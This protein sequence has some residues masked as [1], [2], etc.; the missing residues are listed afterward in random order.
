M[1]MAIPIVMMAGAAISAMGAI[2]Q[3]NAAKAT[4]GYNAQLR[5][6]DASVALDQSKQDAARVARRTEEAQGS[7]LAGYGAS[8][9]TSDGSPLDVLRQS[10]AEGQLDQDTLLY[11]GRLKATGY[12]DSAELDRMQGRTATEQGRW[13]AASQLLTGVGRAGSTYAAGQRPLSYGDY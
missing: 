10:A 13:N 1:A 5:E 8:G 11:R 7:L 12:A 4:A 9:V 6:R 2:S 3:A